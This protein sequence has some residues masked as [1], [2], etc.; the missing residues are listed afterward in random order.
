ML[1]TKLALRLARKWQTVW[2]ASRK[3]KSVLDS[4]WE[5]LESRF[6]IVQQVRQRL[7][8]ISCRHF[9]V[10]ARTLTADLGYHL[11]ELSRQVTNLRDELT[12]K[13]PPPPDLVSWLA[14]VR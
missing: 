12:A 8:F 10:G 6:D 11:G 2:E 1:T 13:R 5:R 3:P 9:T 14:D 7:G 4:P